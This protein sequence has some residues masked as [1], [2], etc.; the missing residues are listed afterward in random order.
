[1]NNTTATGLAI[2]NAICDEADLL[3]FE[4]FTVISPSDT[5]AVFSKWFFASTTEGYSTVDRR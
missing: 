1:M 5:E 4:S 3:F 2:F